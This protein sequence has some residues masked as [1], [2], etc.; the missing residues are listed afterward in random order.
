MGDH[1]VSP[2]IGENMSSESCS[3]AQ[4]SDAAKRELE[5]IALQGRMR[6]I[7][8]KLLVMS[9]KGGVGKSTV[10]ANLAVSL[11]EAGKKVG[12]LDVDVHGPSIPTLMGL[13][14]QKVGTDGPELIPLELTENLKIMSV[15]F[16]LD[17]PA[18][19]VVWRGPMKYSVIKQFL[20]DVDWGR[21]DYLVIDSPPG[22][23]DEPLAVAQLVGEP[24]A[25]IIVTTPQELALSD[26]RRSVS[27]CKMLNLPVLG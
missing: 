1:F 23:G 18:D 8:M 2:E 15:G 27:F 16:L 12:L 6:D 24:A 9:G 10:A 13:Q 21:L 20:A 26:V 25:A 3:H 22:T 4:S 14:G 7:G 11:A 19:A 5:E 17:N